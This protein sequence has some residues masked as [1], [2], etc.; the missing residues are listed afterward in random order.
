MIRWGHEMDETE[1]RFPWAGRTPEAYQSAYR[2]FVD[3]CRPLAP[4]ARFGWTPKGERGFGAYYPGDRHVDFVGLTLFDLQAWNRDH[5]DWRPLDEKFGELHGQVVGF[6]KPVVLAEFGS[7]GEDAYQAQW[8]SCA[9]E[10]LARFGNV[11]ALVYFNARE[12][13][14]WPEPYG[15][16]DW[17]LPDG[18][19]SR[20]DQRQV[21]LT[22]PDPSP[23]TGRPH[24]GRSASQTR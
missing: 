4:K 22:N 15:Q 3:R 16:P 23:G 14:R 19:L 24:E 9:R 21:L 11:E 2:Y 20:C 17:R 1:G 18:R 10:R 6:G 5:K 8:L 13:W 7:G 12:T